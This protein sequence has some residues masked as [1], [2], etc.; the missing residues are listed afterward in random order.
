MGQ[1]RVHPVLGSVR[2]AAVSSGGR[3]CA[4]MHRGCWPISL[5]RKALGS[6]HA[7]A[8]HTKRHVIIF[9]DILASAGGEAKTQAFQKLICHFWRR[10]RGNIKLPA[11]CA[12]SPASCYQRALNEKKHTHTFFVSEFRWKLLQWEEWRDFNT[13]HQIISLKLN[14][15]KY[16]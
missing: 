15:I 12:V 2:G 13:L 1:L 7:L 9:R 14:Y 6:A 16:S 8:I 11:V 5:P 3:S 10:G 4:L